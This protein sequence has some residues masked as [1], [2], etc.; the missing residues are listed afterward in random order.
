MYLWRPTHPQY[1]QQMVVTMFR[2]LIIYYNVLGQAHKFQA[3][4]Y[5]AIFETVSY[6]IHQ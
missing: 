1:A 5:L 4:S 6:D 3:L 2:D